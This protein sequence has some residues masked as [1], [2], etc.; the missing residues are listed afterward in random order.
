MSKL[1]KEIDLIEQY[2]EGSLDQEKKRKIDEKISVDE[3]YAENFE[4]YKF[5]IDGI[6]YSGR[7]KLF[8]KI[9]KWDMELSDNFEVESE[10]SIG[11]HF[12]WYYAAASIVILIVAGFLVFSSLNSGYESLVADYYSPY[13]YTPDVKRGGKIEKNSMD[14][15]LQYYDRGQYNQAIQ[16][17]INLEEGQKTEKV[18]FYLANAYQATKNYDEAIDL[19]KQIINTGIHGYGSKWYLAL[20]YLSIDNAEQAIPLLEELKGAPTS[21]SLNANKLLEDLN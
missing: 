21:Y 17:I 7:K 10:H 20:C 2:L 5:L 14:N 15:I 8:T 13:D 3:N 12:K 11:K 18:I 16:M 4:Q 19:Y 1:L 9:K 6:K